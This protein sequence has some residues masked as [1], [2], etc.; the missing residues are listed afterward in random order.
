MAKKLEGNWTDG[1]AL[2]QYILK[3]EYVGDDA[4]GNPVFD[5]T[6]SEIGKLIHSMKYNGHYD[7]SEEIAERCSNFMS[8]W[9]RGITI[10]AIVAVPP[11]KSRDAQPVFLIGEALHDKTSIPFAS[12]ILR[13]D[14]GA[15]VKGIPHEERNIQGCIHQIRPATRPCNIL[16][17]D[18]I[19]STGTTAKECVRVLKQDPLINEIYFLAVAKTKND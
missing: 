16:L 2:D 11:T 17:L 5:S 12:N 9:L 4:F 6:Y 15:E 7:T 10:D 8:S 3:S 1:Y 19:F 14:S 13:K 18:D